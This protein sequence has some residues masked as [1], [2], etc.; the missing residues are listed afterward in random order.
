VRND[1]SGGDSQLGNLVAR[2]MQTRTGVE[3]ELAITNSLGIRAD[4]E[5]GALTNEQMFNVF[6]FENSITVMY[7]SGSEIQETLD[8]VARKSA[9]RGCRT[10]AQVSGV[11]FDMVCSGDCPDGRTSCAKNIVLGECCRGGSP[12]DGCAAGDPDGPIV[13]GACTPVEPTGLYKVAVNDYIA[14][15]GS[16]FEVL[17]RNTSKQ[18]TNVSLRDSLIDFM[19]KQK[20]CEPTVMDIAAPDQPVVARWGNV[21][22]IDSIERHDGRI[23]AVFE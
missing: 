23:R 9:D 10:Q 11:W 21:A 12:A 6:P 20:P 4:F 19:R 8:F 15:G 2:A 3:A 13:G 22:C 7:L 16:G 5:Q 1:L 18:N 17:K 14:Q